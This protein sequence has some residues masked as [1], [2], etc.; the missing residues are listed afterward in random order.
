MLQALG[1]IILNARISRG[2]RGRKKGFM[3]WD[4]IEK[5]AL[6]LSSSDHINKSAVDRFVDKSRK[7]TE[8]FY[9]ETDAGAPGYHDWHCLNKKDRAITGLPKKS[10]NDKLKTKHFDV[11]IN[12]CTDHG[13][14][15]A[16]IASA[17]SATL[18]CSADDSFNV[19][20]MIIQRN[21]TGNVEEY[22]EVVMRY[23]K[24]IRT[25]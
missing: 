10:I 15:S 9:I 14:F 5:V 24:M 25:A 23:L 17:I 11:I 13:I 16:G 20:D 8:V 7:Y 21:S 6:I 1:K 4:N 18:K 12:T 22:L 19:A 2:N 3:P